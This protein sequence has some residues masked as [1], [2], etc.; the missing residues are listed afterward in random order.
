MGSATGDIW[1]IGVCFRAESAG[2]HRRKYAL[3]SFLSSA[4][5]SFSLPYDH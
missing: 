4:L 2:T 1:M 5:R 3:P